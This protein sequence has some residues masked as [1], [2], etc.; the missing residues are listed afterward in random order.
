METIKIY[1]ADLAEYNNGNL[2]GKWIT[3]PNDNLWSEVQ[4]MLGSNEEWAIHDYEAP[5]SIS[6][7]ADLDEL[8]TI[9]EQYQ[10]LDVQEIKKINYLMDYQG[11]TMAKALEH[12]EDVHI[13]EQTTYLELAYDQV[14]EGLFGEVPDHLVNYLDYEMIARDLE[15]D[16]VQINND[17]YYS[18]Y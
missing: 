6:E 7:Y 2:V 10:E 14:D 13:Y 11:E 18:Q 3:L 8:N 16:Y 1:V 4:E 9:A 17:L 12:Q 15:C 5:F